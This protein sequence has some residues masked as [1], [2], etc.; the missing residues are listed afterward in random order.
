LAEALR[1]HAEPSPLVEHQ[2]ALLNAD[3]AL[4]R[5]QHALAERPLPLPSAHGAAGGSR[6]TKAGPDDAQASA[7]QSRSTG[8]HE[9]ST[10]AIDALELQAKTRQA[11]DFD[12]G[13]FTSSKGRSNTAHVARSGRSKQQVLNAVGPAQIESVQRTEI[14]VEYREQVSRYFSGD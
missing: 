9:G 4:T 10:S 11:L 5:L 8:D 12:R 13:V 14:P 3:R 2:Q 6:G 1:Q 7:G